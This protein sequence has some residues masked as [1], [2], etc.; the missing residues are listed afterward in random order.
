MFSHGRRKVFAVRQRQ[1]QRKE[2]KTERQTVEKR[3]ESIEEMVYKEKKVKQRYLNC[4]LKYVVFF[5]MAKIKQ[6][7]FLYFIL[8]S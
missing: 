6:N 2:Q 7:S 4:R 5:E 3:L 1:E 8:L